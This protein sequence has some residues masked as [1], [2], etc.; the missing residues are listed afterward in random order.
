MVHVAGVFDG[1]RR[2]GAADQQRRRP[3]LRRR[4]LRPIRHRVWLPHARQRRRGA[5]V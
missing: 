3:D 2:S 1:S 4:A 5:Q